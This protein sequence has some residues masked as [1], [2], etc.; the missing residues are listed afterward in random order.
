MLAYRN[1]PIGTV[2]TGDDSQQL[3]DR[4]FTTYVQEMLTRRRNDQHSARQTVRRLAF[5]AQYT[6]LH[7]QTVFTPE[8]LDRFAVLWF[9]PGRLSSP[10][11]R[12]S[13]AC[14]MVGALMLGTTGLAAYGW[15]GG[16]AGAVIGAAVGLLSFERIDTST[17]SFNLL[18]RDQELTPM[19]F[20]G[21]PRPPA[22]PGVSD[23]TARNPKERRIRDWVLDVLIGASELG[24]NPGALWVTVG[25]AVAAGV[26]L[27]GPGNLVMIVTYGAATAVAVL[28]AVSL[29]N[30]WGYLVRDLQAATARER[31]REVPGPI[32]RAV[33]RGGLL[34]ALVVALA[35]P[36]LP[37][38]LVA[39]LVSS[40]DGVRFAA[41]V[42]VGAAMLTLVWLG[43]FAVVEQV[44][45]RL[46]LRKLD[47]APLPLRPFLDYATQCLFLRQVG[48]GYLFVHL[49]LL[50]FFADMWR[51]DDVPAER[52]DE[53][54]PS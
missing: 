31:S 9:L 15:R 33:I 22:H 2:A 13:L 18:R 25:A 23:Q 10:T 46:T 4:L 28:T 21:I 49:S 42:A 47:L 14:G 34:A 54:A 8:L 35:T 24:D 50:E 6:K 44:M 43:G 17:L 32:A 12:S 51:L 52:L 27:G 45:V 1:A 19:T 20:T 36:I 3:R 11:M 16:L 48:D 7:S 38:L 40:A 41:V 53:L 30:G 39:W 26:L 37:G 29:C 5:L